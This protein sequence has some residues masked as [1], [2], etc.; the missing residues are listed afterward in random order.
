MLSRSVPLTQ[1]LSANDHP[2]GTRANGHVL[3]ERNGNMSDEDKA[4]RH[5]IFILRLDRDDR[6]RIT[7]ISERVRSGEKARVNGL[8]GV[9][10]ILAAMLAR[11]DAEPR[12]R[13]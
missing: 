8:D 12:S 13:A 11:E 9:G 2:N 10:A 7:G 4:V 6:G 3:E 5:S 1:R